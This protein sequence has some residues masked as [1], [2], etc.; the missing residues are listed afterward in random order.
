[1]VIHILGKHGSAQCEP[2]KK[3]K[4]NTNQKGK[5][6]NMHTHTLYRAMHYK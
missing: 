2:K 4:S 6:R 5:Q 1:M 3:G